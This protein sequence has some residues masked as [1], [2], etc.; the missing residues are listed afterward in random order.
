MIE[1]QVLGDIGPTTEA[2][3][4]H[5]MLVCQRDKFLSKNYFHLAYLAVLVTSWVQDKVRIP[6][7]PALSD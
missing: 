7:E 6:L 5:I 2:N 3:K 4:H 1:N